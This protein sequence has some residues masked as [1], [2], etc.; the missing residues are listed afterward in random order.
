MQNVFFKDFNNELIIPNSYQ[1]IRLLFVLFWGIGVSILF[2]LL[3]LTSNSTFFYLGFFLLIPPLFLF[4]EKEIFCLIS[5]L[6]P[7]LFMFKQ[8]GNPSAFLGYYFMFVALKYFFFNF[9][10]APFDLLLLLHFI[11]CLITIVLYEDYNLLGICIRYVVNFYLFFVFALMLKKEEIDLVLSSYIVGVMVAIATAMIYHSVNGLLYNGLFGGIN[12][13]RNYFASA[14]SPV[15]CIIILSFMESNP[16]L[17]KNILYSVA[18]ILYAISIFLS[19]SRTAVIALLFP[20]TLLFLYLPKNRID[21]NIL[22]KYVLLVVL[23]LCVTFYVF[24]NYGDSID[25]LFSRFGQDNIE[26]G[27]HRTELWSYYYM[28]STSSIFTF[29][30]GNASFYDMNVYVEHNTF[31]QGLNQTGIMGI[32]SFILVFLGSFFVLVKN[33]IH[34]LKFKGFFPLFVVLFSY[35]GINAYHS[36]QF[37]FLVILSFLMIKRYSKEE[38]RVNKRFLA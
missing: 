35:F 27:N 34:S 33:E 11:F 1:S 28:R 15:F 3:Y 8:I 22:K 17:R 23:L 16:T 7:N 29:L 13:G 10:K 24:S 32:L 18:L 37:S 21:F 36:D 14:I 9:R 38:N 2:L 30:W 12:S 6:M 20:I 19:G 26:T 5:F 25:Y 4:S 31:I